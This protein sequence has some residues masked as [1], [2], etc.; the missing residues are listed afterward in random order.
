MRKILKPEFFE[1][2]ALAVARDLIG[3]FLV[4]KID[5]K[6]IAL[7]I[8]ETEAYGGFRDL[9][10]HSRF[11]KTPR[12]SVMFG[13]PGHIYVYFTYGMHWMLNI[14]CGKEEYPAAVLIR[15]AGQFI[16]PARLTKALHI[17]K[18]LN[19]LLLGKKAGL[20]IEDR[21]VKIPKKA[22]IATPRVGI[23]N[24]GPIWKERPWRFVHLQKTDDGKTAR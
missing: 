8:T 16:G 6:E 2:S 15:A 18:S 7:I 12:T 23:N 19:G 1:R 13:P 4:R 20:W 11:G 22:I 3:K 17:D 10:S 5:G 24:S 9:A 14:V 21:G